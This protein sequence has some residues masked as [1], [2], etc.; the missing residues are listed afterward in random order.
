MKILATKRSW[1][2]FKSDSGNDA[3]DEVVDERGTHEDILKFAS[4]ADIVVCCL[5]MNKDTVTPLPLVLCT[6]LIQNALIWIYVSH[7]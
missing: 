4:R 5:V 6:F 3:H 2:S 1:P 7:F